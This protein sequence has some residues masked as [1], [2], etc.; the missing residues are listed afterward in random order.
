MFNNSL[1]P[2]NWWSHNKYQWINEIY[3]TMFQNCSAFVHVTKV[4]VWRFTSVLQL[5]SIMILPLNLL[6]LDS[7]LMGP[8]PIKV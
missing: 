3:T 8:A 4:I 1:S 5:Q 2:S 7:Y 6:V